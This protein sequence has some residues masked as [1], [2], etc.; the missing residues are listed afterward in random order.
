MNLRSLQWKEILLL[1]AAGWT[2]TLVIVHQSIIASSSYFL[3]RLIEAFQSGRDFSPFLLTYLAAMLLPYIPGCASLLTLQLWIN[4]AHRRFSNRLSESTY[5]FIEKHRDN[6]LRE[7]I[8]SV[9]SRNSFIALQDYLTFIYQFASLLLNST[10]SMTVLSLLLP[11]N[12]ILGYTISILGATTLILLLRRRVYLRSTQTENTFI[13]Y[14]E[15]LSQIWDNSVLGNR[16]NFDLWKQHRDRLASQYYSRSNRLQLL[17]Q[18]GNLTLAFLSLIPTVYLI[19]SAIYRHGVESALIAAII[20]N[21]TRVFH[22]LNSLSGL[23][24]QILD[25]TAMNARVQVLLNAERRFMEPTALPEAPQGQ[26]LVNDSP[27]HQYE[28]VVEVI[29]NSVSGRFTIRGAN[30]SGKS[31]LLHVLKKALSSEAILVPSHH[32]KLQWRTTS[33]N[34]STGQRAVSQLL[35]ISS[36]PEVR[37]LL[38]DEWDANLDAANTHAVD[39]LRAVSSENR[40]VFEKRD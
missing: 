24:Y 9:Y 8:E 12:L 13:S 35:E 17:K 15:A 19:L 40:V 10:L 6:S 3:T 36:H 7:T 29:R 23:V 11:G 16:Y 28:S 34:Q 14:S 4:Q 21:L 39:E 33:A 37:Y 5:G 32:G 27:V 20:V 26:V 1:P 31:T 22:I 18:S 2:L 38:L 30:G 25:F